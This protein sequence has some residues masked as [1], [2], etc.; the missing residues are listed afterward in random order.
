[1]IRLCIL[2]AILVGFFGTTALALSSADIKLVQEKLSD[3]GAGKADGKMGRKTREAILAYQRD[4]QITESGKITSDLIAMLKREHPRTKPQWFTVS[5]QDCEVWN[6]TPRPRGVFTWTGDCVGGKTGGT[7]KLVWWY[8]EQGEQKKSTNDGEYKNGKLHGR[9][10]HTFAS[11]DHYDGEWKD[12]K[13]HGRGVHTYTNGDR[14]DGDWKDD[15]K[16][17]RG[18]YTWADGERYDGEYKDDKRHG[19]GSYTF[20]SGDRYD[21]E[22]KDDKANGRGVSAFASGGGYNGEYKDDK[23]HG[24]GVHT[25]ASGDRYDGEWKDHKQYGRG[26]Y[27][28][29]NGNSYDGEWKDGKSH[30][31]GTYITASGKRENRR[32]TNG[33]S[34]LN[35][36]NRWIGTTKQAC[37]F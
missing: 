23:R 34:T 6:E 3:Y 30:G 33:C 22:W 10:V 20:A 13:R 32:W 37:G 35:R 26:V 28:F 36:R 18:V 4:W 1:M 15:K 2:Q 14:Y 16:H 24:R 29:A 9:G 12:D 19:R 21:G 17:G 31:R 11:G 27:T 8:V 7:G 25:W 5:N